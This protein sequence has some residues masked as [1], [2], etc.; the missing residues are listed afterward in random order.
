[1]LR[2]YDVVL[3]TLRTM[4]PVVGK[5]AEHDADLAR[6]LRRAATSMLLNLGE[7]AGGRGGTRRQRYFDALGSARE[8]AACLDAADALGYCAIDAALRDRIERIA[9]TLV[10]LTR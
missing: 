8:S 6:Q 5:I 3:D 1:M 4:K 2:L 7:G 10:R 9:A